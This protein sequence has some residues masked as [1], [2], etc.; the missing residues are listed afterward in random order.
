MDNEYQQATEDQVMQDRMR[1]HRHQR[2]AVVIRNDLYPGRQSPVAVHLV[3]FGLDTRDDVVGVIDAAHDDNRQRDIAVV[4]LA[5]DTQARNVADRN[6]GHVLDL[7]WCAVHLTEDDVLDV[8]NSPA[9]RQIG[10][11]A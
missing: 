5:G 2:R 7:Y 4:I 3:D 10:V 6:L 1:G 8:V 9:L 11:A